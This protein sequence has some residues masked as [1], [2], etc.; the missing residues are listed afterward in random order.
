MYYFDATIGLVFTSQTAVDACYDCLN[1]ERL[2]D[3][4]TNSPV[5]TVGKATTQSGIIYT[6]VCSTN[7]N[8]CTVGK[9]GLVCSKSPCHNAQLLS[10]HIIEC[11]CHYITCNTI[12]I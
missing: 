11:K 5:F 2:D 1:G 3:E 9:L 12:M 10:Q 6:Y 7:V 8:T 4:W